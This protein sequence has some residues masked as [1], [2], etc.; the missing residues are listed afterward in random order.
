MKNLFK[1]ID[2][3]LILHYAAYSRWHLR[4]KLRQIAQG[5]RLE[6]DMQDD[7]GIGITSEVL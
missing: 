3:W 4:R 7:T 5:E 1:S 2:Q 6:C